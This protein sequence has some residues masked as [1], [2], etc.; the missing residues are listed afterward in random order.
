MLL[1]LGQ[2]EGRGPGEACREKMGVFSI[3]VFAMWG[4][5]VPERH[6]EDAITIQ[7]LFLDPALE[8][9]LPTYLRV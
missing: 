6:Q 4:A 2:R 5:Q 7:C 9:Y 3:V 1:S 8:A